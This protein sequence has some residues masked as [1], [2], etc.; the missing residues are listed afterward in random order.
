MDQMYQLVLHKRTL[1]QKC[2]RNLKKMKGKIL[3]LF[4]LILKHE[5]VVKY[6]VQSLIIL[7]L[8]LVSSRILVNYTGEKYMEDL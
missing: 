3:K 6:I 8:I 2:Q 4:Y 7:T 5:E 1:S